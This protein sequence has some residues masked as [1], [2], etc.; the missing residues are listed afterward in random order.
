[1]DAFKNIVFSILTLCLLLG[2]LNSCEESEPEPTCPDLTG[3]WEWVKFIGGFG[4]DTITPADL[5][6]TK[7][8]VITSDTFSVFL[9]DTLNSMTTFTCEVMS[10]THF[11]Y[12]YMKLESGEIYF[13]KTYLD[14]L[15]LE[16][17]ALGGNQDVYTRK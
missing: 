7:T 4:G 2:T 17:T 13:P 15:I 6:I 14:M 3:E 10:N 11:S 1:M 5:G 12:N 16:S 8:L 9:N